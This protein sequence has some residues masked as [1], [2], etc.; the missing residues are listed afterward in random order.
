MAWAGPDGGGG[1]EEPVLARNTTLLK[2]VRTH[3]GFLLRLMAGG[4]HVMLYQQNVS[5]GKWDDLNSGGGMLNLALGGSPTEN[6]SIFFDLTLGFPNIVSAGIGIGG[7]F[8]NNWHVD[9][10]FGY[11]FMANQY[12]SL[13]LGKEW[14]IS[15]QW[16][17]GVAVKGTVSGT[18]PDFKGGVLT[19]SYLC[20]TATYN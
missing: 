14:W 1:N 8:G 15:E 19:T 16:G 6:L 17:M 18:L 10:A 13:T 4:G 7:Y 11:S 12:L 20:L 3:D 9:A 2:G 5:S